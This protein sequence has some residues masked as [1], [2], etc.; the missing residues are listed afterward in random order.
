MTFLKITT[1]LDEIIHKAV[2]SSFVVAS[3][4]R[5]SGRERMH[6]FNLLRN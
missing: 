3:V 4:W 6:M 5:R 2:A 1:W